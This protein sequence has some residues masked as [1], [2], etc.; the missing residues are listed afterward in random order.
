LSVKHTANAS[1]QFANMEK[2]VQTYLQKKDA[3]FA[4]LAK[5]AE[6]PMSLATAEN[7]LAGFVT[8]GKELSARSINQGKK[9]ANLFLSGKGNQGETRY[10]LLNGVTE[11]FTHHASDNASKSMA[12]NMLGT[13]ATRKTD[14]L[15]TLLDDTALDVMTRQ[16]ERLLEEANASLI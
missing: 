1:V 10:D 3:H 13:Y 14:M 9:M 16:G 7:V 12:S 2:V 8:D 15:D 5:L 11:F 4:N 6:M